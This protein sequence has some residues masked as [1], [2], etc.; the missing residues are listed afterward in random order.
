MSVRSDMEL[1]EE[2]LIAVAEVPTA[3]TYSNMNILVKQQITNI[4]FTF[5]LSP[6]KL[7]NRG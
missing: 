2:K 5:E 4:N 3:K 7:R 6:L 1:I